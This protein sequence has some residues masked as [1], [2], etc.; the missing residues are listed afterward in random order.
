MSDPQLPP[1]FSGGEHGNT[2]ELH[3]S[4]KPL[5]ERYGVDVYLCGHD[6]TLQ[7]T[8]SPLFFFDQTLAPF[9]LT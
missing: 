6:H 1:I 9:H 8:S 5:L 4:V 3:A 2:P 7:V